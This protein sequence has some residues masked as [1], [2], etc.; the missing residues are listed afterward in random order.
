VRPLRTEDHAACVKAREYAELPEGQRAGELLTLSQLTPSSFRKMIQ[1]R[2]QWADLDQLYVISAFL[3]EDGS[4]VGDTMLFDVFR[5][6]YAR[7]EIGTV[8]ASALQ[9][10][11]LGPE[12][13]AGTLSWGWREL[14]L[15][16]IRGFVE[17][18]NP[19]STVAC[20]RSGF[21][22]TTS[23]PIPRRFQGETRWGWPI[24]MRAPQ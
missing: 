22:L 12:L 15:L 11:G 23:G 5:T 16:E 21:S 6:P 4:F 24:V 1:R 20:L 10:R 17:D 19:A 18:E 9:G 13:I 2:A 3:R 14:G 8:L 7:A